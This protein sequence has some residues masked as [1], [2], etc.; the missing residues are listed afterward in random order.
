MIAGWCYDSVSS[1]GCRQPPGTCKLRH[2]ITKCSCG[3]VLYTYSYESHIHGRRHQ[4]IFAG[5]QPPVSRRRTGARTKQQCPHCRPSR[6]YRENE[7]Q[8][9]IA[10][11][12]VQERLQTALEDAQ[13]DK[14][15]I[16]VS[17]P[18]G[19]DFGII[20]EAKQQSAMVV[21]L[22][23][24]TNQDDTA[25]PISLTKCRMLSSQRQDEP[26]DKFSVTVAPTSRFIRSG[27]PHKIFITF[28]PSYA[29]RFEDT[30]ELVFFD[31]SQRRRFVIQRKVCATVGDLAD[32]KQLAPKALYTQRKCRNIELDGPI[33][34]SLRPPTWTPTKWVSK[35]PQFD[36]PQKLV[37]TL[38][39]PEGYLKKSALQDVKQFLPSSFTTPTYAQHF[40]TLVYLEEQQ[41]KLD[42]DDY[43]MENVEIKAKYPRY[44]L[45]VEG[46]SEGRP[47]VVVGDF[48]LIRPVGQPDKTWFEGRVHSV[49]MRHVSLR[50]SDD[51]NTYRGTKFDVRFV[52]NRLSFR[53]MHRA[54][55]NKNDPARL[56]FPGPEHLTMARPVTSAML[57]EIA[58]LNRDIGRNREQLE[59]V[60]AIV[61]QQRGSVPFIV[62]G[63]PG[64]GKTVT[65]VEAIEQLLKRDPNSRILACT[66]NNSAADLIAQKLMHLGPTDV[67]RLNSMTRKLGDLPKTL[68]KFSLTNDNEVFA[69]PALERVLKYRVVVSTCIS[70]GALPDLGVKLGHFTCIFIDEAGQG[71][72]PEIMIPIKGL[73]NKHTNVVLAGDLKQLGPIVHSRLARDL[74]LK[75]SYLAR[76]MQRPCYGLSP[77]DGGVSGGLGVTIMQLVK[78]FRSHPDILAFPNEKFYGNQLQA[79]GDP[80]LT[81]SLETTDELPTKRFPIVF[82][83]VVGRDQRESSSPS[84]FNISEATLVKKYCASLIAKKGIRAE[85][86]AVI[87]PYHAQRM[88]ILDLFHRDAKLSDIRVGS[89]EEF[90]GQERRIIIMSTVRS[91]AEFITS[92]IRRT[93]GFVASPHRFNVAVTRAQALLVVIGNSDVLALDPLWRS[94]MNYIHIKGGWRGHRISWDPKAN[95]DDFAEGV[96]SKAA[97]DAEET[98]ARLKALIVSVGEGGDAIPLADS[99]ADEI[100]GGLGDGLVLREED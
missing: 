96:R 98:M 89:V 94:F 30:L 65:I 49:A 45:Q 57:E 32:H 68:R 99:D 82:H 42:L 67:F 52:L 71:K 61:H 10:T 90:Q 53:R 78:N 11:H 76:L 4:Q 54:L 66:P 12:T 51:F 13:R 3:L 58:P 29:G 75:E 97:G 72:E 93:L 34:H 18:E 22:V 26:G 21:A 24:R 55:V 60:A 83:S 15:G 8:A 44:E 9:H 63:P 95:V 7:L 17:G 36:I 27:Q 25:V 74:G 92:D 41:M 88:K 50:L 91:N 14:Y 59:T 6:E 33:K 47:S 23:Q 28:H 35:L 77:W 37:S 85:H 56:L 100:D 38:Y 80:L 48:I 43:S 31:I 19:I 87:T 70:A 84:F 69:M 79:C 81:K 62:F 16:V 40:Q 46:L 86:I 2:D 5:I 1:S 20:D 64:T 73:A 39:T